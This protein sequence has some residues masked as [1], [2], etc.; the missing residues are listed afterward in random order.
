M[1]VMD[2]VKGVMNRLVWWFAVISLSGEIV[3]FE[4]YRDKSTCQIAR[5]PY[6]RTNLQVTTCQWK[7]GSYHKD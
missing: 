4:G 1:A 6:T 7:G 3:Y 2:A 5:L